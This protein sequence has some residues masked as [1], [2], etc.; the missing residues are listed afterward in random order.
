MDGKW[1]RAHSNTSA[2][3]ADRKLSTRA[4]AYVNRSYSP[5]FTLELLRK[6]FDLGLD[7][8][9]DLDV[10]LPTMELVRARIQDAIR[11]GDIAPG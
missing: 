10:P 3:D 8:G 1:H 9:A 7:A 6:D 11:D 5:T 2:L 4:T